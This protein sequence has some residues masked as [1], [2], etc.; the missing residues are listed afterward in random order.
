MKNIFIIRKISLVA[1]STVS[2]CTLLIFGLLLGGL[3]IKAADVTPPGQPASGPGGADSAYGDVVTS[4]YGEG[5]SQYWIFE[6]STPTP[7]SA[8]LIIFNHGYLGID[9]SSYIGWI[10]HLVRRGNIVVFPAYQEVTSD[11]SQFADN[12]IAAVKNALTNLNSGGHVLPELD[13]VAIMGHSLGGVITSIMA[14]TADTTGLPVPKAIMLVEASDGSNIIENNLLSV[15][16]SQVPSDVLMVAVTAADDTIAGSE[17]SERAI[18]ETTRIPPENKNLVIVRSDN[19]GTPSLTADHIAPLCPETTGG[20]LTDSV[21]GII[22]ATINTLDYYAFWKIGDG[23]TQAA[24]NINR[25]ENIKYALGNTPEQRF[26]GL[27]SDGVPVTELEVILAPTPTPT[28]TPIPE[29]AP[30]PI[31]G[32]ETGSGSTGGGS[33]RTYL[34]QY[35]TGTPGVFTS[36]FSTKSWDGLLKLVF[37][38]GTK[39][40]TSEG[41]ALSYITVKPIA[42]DKQDLPPP[43][44]GNLVGLTYEL[45]PEG[46]TFSP[47]ASITLVYY[48]E[49]IP[50]GISEKDLVIGYWDSESEQWVALENCSVDTGNNTITA[51]LSH[52][53]TYSILGYP[54]KPAPA[55]FSISNL[56]ISPLEARIG[57]EV[58]VSVRVSNTGGSPGS[59]S[60]Q[61]EINDAVVDS[62][63]IN[64]EAGQ[65]TLVSFQTR[66]TNSGKYRIAIEGETGQ[67]NVKAVDPV[68]SKEPITPGPV[69]IATPVVTTTSAVQNTPALITPMT[70]TSPAAQDPKPSFPVVWMVTGV[71]AVLAITGSVVLILR[72]SGGKKG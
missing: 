65:S 2:L 35:M 18:R 61:L 51:S 56:N 72:K 28:T 29:P 15:D 14:S 25:A 36:E 69:A 26:M 34:Y 23:L 48:D 39:G 24:F 59:Y 71:L 5:V 64:L 67:F 9:P 53:S 3:P 21:M 41:W 33:D 20:D 42:K 46:A 12:A 43:D 13:K 55:S 8:P 10:K 44:Q 7:Q 31:S 54:P 16:F 30:L 66:G 49:Q 6:P 4:T 52:F 19:H 70:T 63:E 40:Q 57:E 50:T 47:P 32:E 68:P 38:A 45:A 11:P 62:R 27:W 22:G 37:P 58:S 17:F 60:I 1:L